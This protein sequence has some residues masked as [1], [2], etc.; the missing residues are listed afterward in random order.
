MRIF[1]ITG[2]IFYGFAATSIPQNDSAHFLNLPRRLQMPWC[3]LELA[4][5]GGRL[6]RKTNRLT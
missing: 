6:W 4:E 1:L 2:E 3:R 5:M